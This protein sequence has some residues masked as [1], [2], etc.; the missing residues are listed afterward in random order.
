MPQ[1][2]AAYVQRRALK[3]EHIPDFRN[4][5]RTSAKLEIHH[6]MSSELMQ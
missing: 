5:A 1:E 4:D 6:Q 3:L 2:S